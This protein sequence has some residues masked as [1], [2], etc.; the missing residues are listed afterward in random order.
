MDKINGLANWLANLKSSDFVVAFYIANNNYNYYSWIKCLASN[1]NKN[2]IKTVALYDGATDPLSK[3]IFSYQENID[4]YNLQKFERINILLTN[5]VYE[6]IELSPKIKVL[7][8]CD[9]I[10]NYSADL[11]YYTLKKYANLLSM[12]DG[13][14]C[15]LII[16]E[17]RRKSIEETWTGL[18]DIEFISRQAP[19]FYIIPADK[20]IEKSQEKIG[21]YVQQIDCI[22]YMP[23]IYN[24]NNRNKKGEHERLIRI[25]LE[26]FPEL[27]IYYIPQ[28]IPDEI[29]ENVCNFFA[30]NNRFGYLTSPDNC[31]C[32]N[33]VVVSNSINVIK[34]YS[35]CRFMPVILFDAKTENHLYPES[36]PNIKLAK[37]Y[38]NL[39]YAVKAI[40][41]INYV[42]DG[43]SLYNFIPEISVLLRNFYQENAAAN[44]ICIARGGAEAQDSDAL[45]RILSKP[46]YMDMGIISPLV[47]HAYPSSPLMLAFA[48][49]SGMLLTP[50]AV[51]TSA[52]SRVVS[53]QLGKST[54]NCKY[55]NIS[56][57]DIESLYSKA[58]LE[59]IKQKD[60]AG[61]NVVEEAMKAFN[62][63]KD[64]IL[65]RNSHRLPS[66]LNIL[67]EKNSVNKKQIL[68][69]TELNNIINSFPDNKFIVAFYINNVYHNQFEWMDAL[70][71]ECN[72]LGYVTVGLYTEKD[73]YISPF[74]T[75]QYNC[76][77]NPFEIKNIK[78]LSVVI[79]SDKDHYTIWPEKCKILECVHTFNYEAISNS[80]S[81]LIAHSPFVDGIMVPMPI[82]DMVKHKVQ[83]LWHGI[84]DNKLS[85]H[86]NNK[87]SFIPVGY[88]RLAAMYANLKQS[89]IEPD[90]ITYAPVVIDHANEEKFGGERINK[91]GSIIIKILLDNFPKHKIIFR[92][93]YTDILNPAVQEIQSIFADEP[94]F[95]FDT[96]P[97]QL[98]PFSHSDIIITDKSNVVKSFAFLTLRPGI[99]F[100][101]WKDFPMPYIRTEEGFIVN[102]YNGLIETINLVLQNPTEESEIIRQNRDKKIIPF[103]GALKKVAE[104]LPDFY[105]GKSRKNWLTIDLCDD[106]NDINENEMIQ[107]IVDNVLGNAIY[108]SSTLAIYRFPYK[109][110]STA[111]ALH[112][113]KRESKTHGISPDLIKMAEQFLNKKIPLFY[114]DLEANDIRSIYQ[115]AKQDKITQK[116]IVGEKL[117]E[118][119][120]DMFEND[121]I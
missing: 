111:F 107:K 64:E 59:K 113:G 91:Y 120:L 55:R 34:E 30:N 119:L 8:F 76:K 24:E 38:T 9:A 57:T 86:K 1:L 58:L 92:P 84:I 11:N 114:R 99:S 6:E 41:N 36:Y 22:F 7:Y 32:T 60:N 42:N 96:N 78:N 51:I 61:R 79:I 29:T 90:S 110:L 72:K 44:W 115:Y 82:D 10:K 48:L 40:K 117:I 20:N 103:E 46:D 45:K 97:E 50:D 12:V 26:N 94:R 81:Y 67:N 116:D 80:F 108:C 100:Q 13:W 15:P 31:A 75:T 71:E 104:F 106:S 2:G 23:Q 69:L 21:S 77:L 28:N 101:P 70:S 65:N 66:K 27:K 95:V 52:I 49:H 25:L 88:P 89:A 83:N 17:D 102:N 85:P 112:M 47:A 5:H 53:E 87:L 73:N 3:S 118:T 33:P 19:N 93:T 14:I 39:I 68:S 54:D 63:L 105:K 98:F 18:V 56:L 62:N 16:D 37:N 109:P 4:F 43:V 35:P 121:F 74:T